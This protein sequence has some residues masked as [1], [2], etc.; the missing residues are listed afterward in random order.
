MRAC[1]DITHL[2]SAVR[3]VEVKTGRPVKI[4]ADCR[5]NAAQSLLRAG[6]WIEAACGAEPLN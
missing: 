5:E 4:S 2:G 6:Y 1:G 3:S